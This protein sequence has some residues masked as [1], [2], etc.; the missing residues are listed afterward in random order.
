MNQECDAFVTVH[1][2]LKDGVNSD[3]VEKILLKT[4][5]KKEKYIVV[6]I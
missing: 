6:G 5:L 1:M 4:E 3:E 2:R